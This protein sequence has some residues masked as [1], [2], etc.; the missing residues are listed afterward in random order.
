M[1]LIAIYKESK[2]SG[3][4]LKLPATKILQRDSIPKQGKETTDRTF[5]S[6]LQ[7]AT[8]IP[9]EC[10]ISLRIALDIIKKSSFPIML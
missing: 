2:P 3:V 9:R 7:V 10:E 5:P 4:P 8:D 1:V 6:F